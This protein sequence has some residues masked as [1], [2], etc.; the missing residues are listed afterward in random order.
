MNKPAAK[1][2]DDALLVLMG[3]V[4]CLYLIVVAY[5]Y[6]DHETLERDRAEVRRER[7]ME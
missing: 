4:V 3:L 5:R 2:L 7:H 6:R 1:Q